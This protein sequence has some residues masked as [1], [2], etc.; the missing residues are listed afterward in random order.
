MTAEQAL[1][2]MFL[3]GSGGLL[4]WIIS[5][6]TKETIRERNITPKATDT[7]ILVMGL[8]SFFLSKGWWKFFA[9]GLAGIGFGRLLIQ[10]EYGELEREGS[11]CPLQRFKAL[12]GFLLLPV[13]P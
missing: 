7:A 11:Q 10:F 3:A 13:P 8:L 4:G 9:A 12:S 5:E 6:C 2:G 1:K